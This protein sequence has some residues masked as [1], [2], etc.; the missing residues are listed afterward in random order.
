MRYAGYSSKISGSK[1]PGPVNPKPLP[2]DPRD[3]KV[4]LVGLSE[5]G[6]PHD[7]IIVDV[8]RPPGPPDP[9]PSVV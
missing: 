5:G 8:P 2:G 1:P 9:G 3:P 7:P 4:S 6:K